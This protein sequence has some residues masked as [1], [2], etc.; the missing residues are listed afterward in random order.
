VADMGWNRCDYCGRFIA[1]A[2]FES[3]K[4]VSYMEHPDTEITR[5]T[6][7]QFHVACEPA[8]IALSGDVPAVIDAAAVRGAG[9]SA[10][11]RAAMH[12]SGDPVPPA[13]RE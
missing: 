4:A 10:V 9:A 8:A 2:D 7:A 13:G 5:E 12:E 6:W 11:E 3:G 1:Y